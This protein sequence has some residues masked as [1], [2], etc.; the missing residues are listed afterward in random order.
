MYRMLGG[1]KLED[2]IHCCVLL[3]VSEESK[4]YRLY[5]HI[6]KRIIINRDV[7]FEEE[8]QWNWERSFEDDRRFNLEW[9][10]GN[11]GEVED[12]DDGSE[13]ENVASPVRD[14]FSDGNEEDEATPPMTPRVRRAPTY[15]NDFV[16]SDGLSDEGKEVQTHLAL[17]ASAVH[18]DPI[19]FDEAVKGEKW[20]TTMDFEMRSIRKNETWDLIE[21]SKGA[22]IIG[23]KWVYKTKLNE[24]GEVDKHKARLVAK[25][26]AQEY[27]V[28]YEE[29]YAPVARMDTVRMIL[30]L[31]TQRRWC[32][33]QLDVKSTFLHGKLTENVYV[34][35][36][37]G[38][39]IKNEEH[40]V[41]KFNKALYG[42]KQTPRAWFNRIES[43]FRKKGFGKEDNEQT[44]FT[45]VNKQGKH[46]IISLY[47]DDLIYTGDD[48]NMMVEFK[49]SV[50]KEFDMTNLGKMK[51]FLSI[52][53]VQFDGGI[54]I[55]QAKYVMEVLRRFGME[56]SNSV[57]NPMVPGF[58][59]SK[60]EN[61]IEMD[62][63]FFK[64]L[65]GSMMYLI[66]TRPNIMYAVSLLSRY[67]S[68]P[69]EVHHSAAKR[70]LCYLQGTTTFGILY[71]RGGSHE[72]I[73]F[74]DNDYAG[75]M[76]DRRSTSGY[77]FMLSGTVVT[78][79]SR[80]QLIVTLN[81]T[82]DKFIAAVGS[83]S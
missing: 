20:R 32:V 73:G 6:S 38:Y 83:G 52:E 53:V 78:W 8:E 51:C 1:T 12:S 4:A 68:R 37:R 77:V 65:I 27:G 54:F 40:K 62:G 70:I 3:G 82:E 63:S 49:E 2:K 11:G 67:M 71:K 36:P 25:E 10:D 58:K 14:E 76:E 60:D 45:K 26:Y 75:S 31:A 22:K 18:Y 46:L 23:A 28:D 69:T 39:E 16:S 15:L 41:Y 66:A 7:I 33:F 50:M 42:L 30:E 35:Q 13:E 72:L 5:N 79:S 17:F 34:E 29:V 81:T 47:V 64:Q 56:H 24:L 43:Y 48:E 80:K 74:T 55:S 21:L 9:E 61:G 44:L 19:L 57:E 59:I